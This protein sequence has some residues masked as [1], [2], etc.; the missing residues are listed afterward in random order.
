VPEIRYF[1]AVSQALAEEMARDE[2]VFV[3]GEDV[4]LVGGTFRATE[5]LMA[6]FGARRVRDT[7][8][9]E[10]SIVGIAIG[11]AMA[12]MRPVAELMTMN[13]AMVAMD[14]IVNHASKMRYMFGGGVRLPLVIRAPGGGGTQKGAQHSHSIESWFVNAPGLRVVIP[15]TPYDLKGLLKTAVRSDDP[16][17]FVEHEMLYSM[18]GEVPEEEYLLPF[19]VA[20]VKR[21]GRDVT[22]I[23]WA[24]MLHEALRAA[25][26]LADEGIEA[27]VIDPRTLDPLDFDT[28]LRS[29]ARTRRCVVAEEGWRNVGVGAEIAARLQEHLFYDLE[30]PVGRV[31]AA[32][33]P[34]PYARNLEKLALPSAQSIFDAV[35][36]ITL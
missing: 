28:I 20:D 35:L 27:E 31:A 29:V 15:S 9:A 30:A 11:A 14:Q 5:G 19:G 18:R 21:P 22:V 10:A 36:K 34:T 32:D 2:R 3:L 26:R 24:R 16:V 17:L 8:I 25:E 33:V 12:G 4:G 23:A 13:F 7:P 6:E 1:E